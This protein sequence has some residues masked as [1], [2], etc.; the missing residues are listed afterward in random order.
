MQP[1]D[2]QNPQDQQPNNGQAGQLPPDAQVYNAPVPGSTPQVV[3]VTRPMDPMP[4]HVSDAAKEK[5]EASKKQYPFLNLSEGEYVISAIKRHPVGLLQIW[6]IVA[7]VFL[8]LFG[9]LAAVAG[10]LF[11]DTGGSDGF[12]VEVV[13]IPLL[14][15]AVI[16][17][18]YGFIETSVYNSNEFFLTNES[19]I[20][21]IQT[22]LFTKRQQTVSLGNV[23]DAS[24]SQ[25]G[26]LPSMLNYGQLRLSTE[27]DETTY[28]F[29]YASHPEK[30]IA[31]LNNAVEAFKNGRPVA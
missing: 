30:Q 9:F 1:S 23:E 27:G 22:S 17:L 26:I 15:V 10:G 24:Y 5:H 18:L 21:F 3:Y 14:L 16:A 31:V 11:G 12:P 29:S 2:S 13:A 19:V 25:S 6:T 20:Q 8:V 4:Q 28:R 7:I